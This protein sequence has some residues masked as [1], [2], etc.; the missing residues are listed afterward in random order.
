MV[1]YYNIL[2]AEKKLAVDSI[3][4]AHK[5]SGF[6]LQ[7]LADVRYYFEHYVSIAA[8]GLD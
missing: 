4:W 2:P 1:S 6:Y 5:I 8:A 3:L 7:T